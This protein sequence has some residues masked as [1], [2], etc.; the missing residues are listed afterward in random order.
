MNDTSKKKKTT[1]S[2]G[3]AAGIIAAWLERGEFPDRALETVTADRAFVQELVFGVVRQRRALEWVLRKLVEREPERPMFALALVGLYQLLWLT[4]VAPF[5]AVHE[6]V[7][8]AKALAGAR[9]ANFLNAVLRRA[10]RETEAL[11]NELKQLQPALRLSHPGARHL[12]VEQH[13]RR[14]RAAHQHRHAGKILRAAQAR[15]YRSEAILRAR[16]RVLHPAAWRARHRC[17]RL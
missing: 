2:R 14:D 1:N 5:A 7:E 3:V 16:P 15:R 8:A 11:A 4:D 6:T 10:Q 17:T 9:A 12:R 13:A